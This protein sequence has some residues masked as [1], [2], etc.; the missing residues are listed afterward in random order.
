MAFYLGKLSQEQQD[1]PQVP[2]AEHNPE[3]RPQPEKDFT[4]RDARMLSR[5]SFTE[6]GL[7][8][9]SGFLPRTLVE[10]SRIFI[11]TDAKP[12]PKIRD[13]LCAQEAKPESGAECINTRLPSVRVLKGLLSTKVKRS[14]A[15]W[16]P[17]ASRWLIKPSVKKPGGPVLMLLNLKA[18]G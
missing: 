14:S 12:P 3:F 7:L 1:S 11:A 15:I 2:P 4:R 6:M 9:H 13:K 5:V 18:G 8:Q 10:R 17:T 16:K